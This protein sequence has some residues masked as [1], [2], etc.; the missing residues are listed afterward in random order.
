M[1]SVVRFVVRWNLLVVCYECLRM[2]FSTGIAVNRET[3]SKE[4]IISSSSM[5]VLDSLCV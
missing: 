5:K 1:S 4:T 3:T 2:F